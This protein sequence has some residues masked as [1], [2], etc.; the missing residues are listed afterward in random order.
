MRKR[1]KRKKRLFDFKNLFQM[2]SLRKFAQ[3]LS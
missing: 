2:R 1:K 3:R